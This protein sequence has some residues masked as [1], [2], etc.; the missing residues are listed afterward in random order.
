MAGGEH[1]GLFKQGKIKYIEVQAMAM[2]AMTAM[3]V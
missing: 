1:L 2:S 3:T